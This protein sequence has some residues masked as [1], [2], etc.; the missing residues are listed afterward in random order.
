MDK[1][2][3][4]QF[5]TMQYSIEYNKQYMNANKQ[6]SYEKMMKITEDL[7]AMLT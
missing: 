2:Y 7:K 3:G 4:E 1:K 5:I 6:D